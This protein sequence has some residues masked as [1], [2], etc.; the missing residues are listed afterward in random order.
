MLES[1]TKLNKITVYSLMLTLTYVATGKLGLMLALPPGYAS[2]IFPPAGIAVAAVFILGR[3]ALAAIFFGSFLLNTW[4]ANAQQPISMTTLQLALLIAGASTVQAWVG[5]AWLKRKIGYPTTLDNPIDVVIFFV[6]API[7]CLISAT[8]SVTSLYTLG[9]ITEPLFFTSWA[10]WWIGDSL[11]LIVMLPLFLVAIGRPRAIW[12]KRLYTIAVPMI[13]TF[14]LLVII[15]VMVSRWEKKESLVEFDTLSN[16]ISEQL[17]IRFESQEAI[18]K[19]TSAL[20]SYRELDTVSSQDFH[21]FVSATLVGYPMIYALEWVP[22]IKRQEREAFV[23]LQKQ[24]FPEFE[25]KRF[26]ATNG[27]TVLGE[28]D[29]YFPIAYIEPFKNTTRAI[30]GFDLSTLPDRSDAILESIRLKKAVATPPTYLVINDGK[31]LG[32]LLMYPVEG[33]QSGVLSTILRAKSFFG[34]LFVP[35]SEVLNARLV[36]TK[37]GRLLYNSF[38]EDQVEALYA[39]IFKFGDREYRLETTPSTQYY[40]QHRGWQSWNLLAVGIFGTGLMGAL[41]LIGTGYTVRIENLVKQKTEDLKESFTRF[42]E[43]TSTL[44]E[45][46]YVVDTNGIITFVNPKAQELLGR[47]EQELLGN[48]AHLLFHHKHIDHSLYPECDCKIRHVIHTKQTYKSGE[49]VFWHK[50]GSPIYSAVSAVPL[51][52]DNLIVGSVVVFDDISDRKKIEQALRASEKSFKEIIE[53]AP[54]GMAIVSLEGK[55]VIV[56]QTLCNIVGYNNDELLSLTFQEITYHE[57]LSTDLVFVQ[58]LLDGKAVTYQMEKRY[59]CKDDRVVWVQLSVSLFRDEENAPQYF[60][61][62]IEDITNRKVRDTEVKQFAY[63]DTLTKLPNRRLLMERLAQEISQAEQH[64]RTI[65]LFFLDLDH[66]KQINDTLGHDAGDLILKE[67]ALRLSACVR[68]HDT[69]SRLGGDEFVIVLTDISDMKDAEIVAEKILNAIQQPIDVNG[70]QVV[71][72]TSIGI[73]IR[74]GDMRLTT[75]ELMK[76]ADIAMYQS[77]AAGRNRYYFYEDS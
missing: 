55:F 19:Q 46:I 68:S 24:A 58:Q 3:S 16:Q 36:D 25:I 76:H 11:G 29:F 60:I 22:K 6:S 50:N 45:G 47:S 26:N 20:F 39:R 54:I 10:S 42:Q 57:D 75:K 4:I 67:S 61:A 52:R 7:V 9:L 27:M 65:A 1:L 40:Q 71:V 8:I 70:Q 37:T 30:L 73:A 18:L 62:Q 41:L 64:K 21:H 32:L 66:F 59:I 17:R 43:I 51:F 77:K 12:R 33:K 2:A 15:F 28:K 34:E 53:F 56:N 69:V 72:G 48:N 74:S 31:E 35:A 14:S 13:I 49:E 63:F 5:G 38:S 44:G 23:R